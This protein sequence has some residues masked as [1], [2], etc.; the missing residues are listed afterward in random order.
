MINDDVI[1]YA[2]PDGVTY[3]AIIGE[4]WFRWPAAAD[5]WRLRVRCPAS[6]AEDCE[7]LSP[8]LAH[9]ALQL[10]SAGAAR[11]QRLHHADCRRR[12]IVISHIRQVGDGAAPG[13]E[14]K[15]AAGGQAQPPDLGT[16]RVQVARHQDR[17]AALAPGVL[18]SLPAR[19]R[20]TPSNS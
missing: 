1:V 18:T 14:P 5:G 7:E 9:L 8:R 16:E 17:I 13:A 3:V 4:D 10:Q 15:R 11:S 6:L 19:S 20:F 12:H 2:H